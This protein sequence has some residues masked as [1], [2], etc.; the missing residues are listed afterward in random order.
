MPHHPWAAPHNQDGEED[1]DVDEDEDEDEDEDDVDEDEVDQK[2]K[3]MKRK[4]VGKLLSL[5]IPLC[6]CPLPP[7]LS[8]AWRL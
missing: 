8:S 3:S 7:L 6:H 1:D 5:I 2:I 4:S